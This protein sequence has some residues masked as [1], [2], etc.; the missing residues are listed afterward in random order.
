MEQLKLANNALAEEALNASYAMC[1]E[2]PLLF[3][4]KGVLAYHCGE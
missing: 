3:N 2:D 4:E 1:P